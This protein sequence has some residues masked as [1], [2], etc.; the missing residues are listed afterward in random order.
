M[1]HSELK[2]W[3]INTSVITLTFTDFDNFLKLVLLIV[4]I[5]YSI[6]KWCM[7]RK[8]KKDKDL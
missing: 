7:L 2:L 8:N 6:D 5:G 1:S 4:T 3:I